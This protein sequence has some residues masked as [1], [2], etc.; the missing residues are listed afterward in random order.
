LSDL[1][2]VIKL[3]RDLLSRS[4]QS[5]PIAI[6]LQSSDPFILVRGIRI[7]KNRTVCNRVSDHQRGIKLRI[8]LLIGG[9]NAKSV[10]REPHPS[11]KEIRISGDQV[12]I[13]VQT[14]QLALI[15]QRLRE[16]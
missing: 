8:D 2:G 16:L 11:R 9:R 15:G 7:I 3:S 12:V 14:L 13:G 4:I 10:F 1:L 5:H 6:Q